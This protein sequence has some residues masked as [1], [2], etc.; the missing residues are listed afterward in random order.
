MDVAHEVA[1]A[2]GAE[3]EREKPGL[4][5]HLVLRGEDVAELGLL[6]DKL[7]LLLGNLALEI[8]DLFVRVVEVAGHVV[9]VVA[10][11]L[12]FAVKG[13]ELLGGLVELGL[14]LFGS[15]GHGA[16]RDGREAEGYNERGGNKLAAFG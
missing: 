2:V 4:V 8:G 16:D 7:G 12:G 15:R 6:C 1:E 11:L 13:H 9:E 3:D 14:E 5:A 10:S